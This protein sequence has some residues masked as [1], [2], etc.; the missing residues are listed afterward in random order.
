MAAIAD[1]HM[2]AKPVSRAQCAAAGI[3]PLIFF[4]RF[5]RTLKATSGVQMLTRSAILLENDP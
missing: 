1:A 5:K 2:E 3:T 4:P